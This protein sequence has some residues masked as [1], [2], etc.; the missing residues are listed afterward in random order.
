[1]SCTAAPLLKETWRIRGS[2]FAEEGTLAHAYR[3]KKLKEFL[4]LSVDEEKAEIAQLDEQYHSGEM[5]EYTDTYK[6][7]VLEKFNAA[8]AKTKDAQLLVEVKLAIL[9]TM[10]LMLSARRTLSLSPMA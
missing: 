10:Y 1:M 2:T 3:A 6:T 7:I 4:G 8:Q 5:D 9:A